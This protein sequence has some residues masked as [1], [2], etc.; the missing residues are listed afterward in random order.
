MYEYTCDL[1]D[2]N[3]IGYTYRHLH[4]RAEEHKNSVIGKHFKDKH[5]LRVTGVRENFKILKKCGSNVTYV[6][7]FRF[8]N[9]DMRS[10]KRH[11]TFFSFIF[12]LKCFSKSI[13]KRNNNNHV[14][15]QF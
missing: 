3:Y 1:C 7:S 6:N 12:L 2:A 13:L 15:S 11:V 10:S 8:D 5:G 4:Q 14:Y 9:N